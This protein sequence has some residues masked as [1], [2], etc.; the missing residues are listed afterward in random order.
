[1]ELSEIVMLAGAVLLKMVLFRLY[2]S[3]VVFVFRL[4]WSEPAL[5]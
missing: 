5:F 3:V 4:D 2:V 1:M